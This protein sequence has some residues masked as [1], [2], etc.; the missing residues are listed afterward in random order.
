MNHKRSFFLFWKIHIVFYIRRLSIIPHLTNSHF[1]F[2]ADIID[3]ILSV[4][5]TEYNVAPTVDA[6]V[7]DGTA[8]V[9]MLRPNDCKTFKDY[10]SVIIQA[11]NSYRL[12]F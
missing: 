4:D 1:V 8:I 11:Y 7:F 3:T 5:H 9:N 12:S 2:V 10:I 6:Q